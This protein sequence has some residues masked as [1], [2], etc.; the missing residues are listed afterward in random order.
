[1]PEE[2][3]TVNVK[4]DDRAREIEAI[5]ARFRRHR[6]ALTALAADAPTIALGLEYN[7]LI[8]ELDAS[9][10]KIDELEP[11]A[12]QP[13]SL[14]DTQPVKRTEPGR[15]PLAHTPV[16]TPPVE[17][18]PRST[19]R[20]L[21]IVF[22]GLVV[23]GAIAWLMW[24]SS[25]D[26]APATETVAAVDTTAPTDTAPATIEPIT[27]APPQPA[28]SGPALTIE[29]AAQDF[30]AI[31]RG[32]SATRQFEITNHTAQPITIEASR[33]KCRCLYYAHNSSVAPQGKET[34]TVTMNTARVKGR[35]LQETIKVADKSNAANETSF[36]VSATI[37]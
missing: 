17:E 20:I 27:P 10:L 19:G 7:R 2:F 9:V 34:I 18:S 33:S 36:N 32:S 37:R 21:L 14:T 15:K 6:E 11:T 5:R 29:P 13:K 30:G 26:K 35:R 3:G 1:M 22:V 23:L 28:Y 24:E 12:P 25:A 16:L 4:R 31:R 8:K